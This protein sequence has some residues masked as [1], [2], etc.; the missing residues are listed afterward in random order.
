LLPAGAARFGVGAVWKKARR[1][2]PGGMQA[3][4]QQGRRLLLMDRR[5][6]IA[7]AWENSLTREAFAPVTDAHDM[8]IF[9]QRGCCDARWQ[10][11]I[12]WSCCTG[13]RTTHRVMRTPGRY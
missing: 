12:R 9:S 13:F 7:W 10:Q 4:D 6:S 1:S 11:Q 5:A 3:G 2:A 8:K